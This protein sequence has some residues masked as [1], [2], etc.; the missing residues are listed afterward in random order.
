MPPISRGLATS[1][2]FVLE[3]VKLDGSRSLPQLWVRLW[4]VSLPD[5]RQ[6]I[7]DLPNE[8]GVPL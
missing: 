4:E 1:N 5:L 7:L 3:E 2:S 6:L 8:E